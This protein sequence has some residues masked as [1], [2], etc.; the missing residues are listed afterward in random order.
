MPETRFDDSR[1]QTGEGVTDGVSQIIAV[2]ASSLPGV[3]AA[4]G[5]RRCSGETG[6]LARYV[7]I[8]GAVAIRWVCDWCEDYYTAGDLPRAI[9][10]NVP[11]ERIPLRVDNSH[12]TYDREPCAVCGLP[13]DEWHHWA[14]RAIFPEWP[15][16][17]VYLCAAHHREWH[18]R[19]R[20]HGLRWPHEL[21]LVS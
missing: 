6:Y 12:H 15:D 13:S 17:G 19:M 18:G 1:T 5:C 9:L 2:K 3:H 14:P 10:G 11:L 20:C 4:D 7:K 8:N 16:M 21:E